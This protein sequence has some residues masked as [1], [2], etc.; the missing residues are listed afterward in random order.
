[1][2]N[3]ICNG[4]TKNLTY[5]FVLDLNVF[6]GTCSPFVRTE[7]N[8]TSS[9]ILIYSHQGAIKAKEGGEEEMLEERGEGEFH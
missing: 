9:H 7:V 1:M 5:D 6:K 4:I 8:F 3:F 2:Y